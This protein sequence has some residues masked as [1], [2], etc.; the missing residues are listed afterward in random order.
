MR[1]DTNS[2]RSARGS[3]QRFADLEI[4]RTLRYVQCLPVDRKNLQIRKGYRDCIKSRRDKIGSQG[5]S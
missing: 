3:V 2:Q 1:G 4:R 5:I